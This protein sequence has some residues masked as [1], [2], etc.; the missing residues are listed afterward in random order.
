MAAGVPGCERQVVLGTSIGKQWRHLR[1]R[2]EIKKKKKQSNLIARGN[3]LLTGSSCRIMHV[4]AQS[5]LTLWD[6]MDYDSPVSSIHGIILA[7]ILKWV[8][9]FFSRGIFPTQR[10]NLHLL[11]L[12]HWQANSLPLSHQRNPPPGRN[13]AKLFVCTD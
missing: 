8:D 3:H 2:R 12:Q 1:G 13:Y 7:R 10:S 4:P 5:C 9:I 6:S 11:W